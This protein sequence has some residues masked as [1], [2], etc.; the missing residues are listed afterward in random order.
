VKA[1]LGD[2]RGFGTAGGWQPQPH[3]AHAERAPNIASASPERWI[4]RTYITY[5]CMRS[6]CARGSTVAAL[7]AQHVFPTQLSQGRTIPQPKTCQNEIVAPPIGDFFPERERLRITPLTIFC[8]PPSCQKIG[9]EADIGLSAHSLGHF[10]LFSKTKPPPKSC[11]SPSNALS[12]ERYT[13][14][15]ECASAVAFAISC[16]LSPYTMAPHAAA[17]S[18]LPARRQKKRTMIFPFSL[19]KVIRSLSLYSPAG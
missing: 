19:I 11:Q 1:G 8:P 18:G 7:R 6:G 4:S 14:S 9:L 15:L 13:A 16:I 10:S 5:G 3:S 12:C 17:R 2:F